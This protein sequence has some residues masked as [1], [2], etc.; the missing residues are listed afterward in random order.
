MPP[1][2][3]TKPRQPS[4]VNPN[5]RVYGLIG[6][7]GIKH[8]FNFIMIFLQTFPWPKEPSTLTH[9]NR[10]SLVSQEVILFRESD[11]LEMHYKKLYSTR[12][13]QRLQGTSISIIII[14]TSIII[15]DWLNLFWER[16]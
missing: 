4:N 8:N 2:N 5:L 16:T 9:E 13:R 12:R 1:S 3:R 6:F 10:E 15:S 7:H 14:M 11:N